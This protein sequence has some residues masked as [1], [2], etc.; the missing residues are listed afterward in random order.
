M[1]TVLTNQI[2]SKVHDL[3]KSTLNLH[4]T[5]F[6]SPVH[7]LQGIIL[8][9]WTQISYSQTRRSIFCEG[10]FQIKYYEEDII[11]MFMIL[12]DIFL[13][14][15]GKVFKQIVGFQMCTNSAPLLP[16]IFLSSYEA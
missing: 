7:R 11:K 4:F 5:A 8:H 6:V 14:F 1:R 2:I 3:Y 9:I 16:D 13:I 12:V 15:V 10:A